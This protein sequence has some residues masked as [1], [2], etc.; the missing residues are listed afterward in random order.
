MLS[1]HERNDFE[2]ENLSEKAEFWNLGTLEVAKKIQNFF[3]DTNWNE[4]WPFDCLND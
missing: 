1:R 3:T 4:K 2:T